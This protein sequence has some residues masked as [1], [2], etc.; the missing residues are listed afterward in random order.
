M[1][2]LA[3]LFI[4]P[5]Q[6]GRSLGNFLLNVSA[7]DSPVF[8]ARSSSGD[9]FLIRFPLPFSFFCSRLVMSATCRRFET[10]QPTDMPTCRRHVADTT[11]T[12]SATWHRV[13]S[14]DAVSVSCQHD[15]LPTCRRHVVDYG[16][17]PP[18]PLLLPMPL[19]RPIH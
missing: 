7:H 1:C 2:H 5:S 10:P 19:Q 18:R 12:M 14:S 15:D 11:Q 8:K 17:H 4:F 6:D 16:R 13:G 9:G 3:H